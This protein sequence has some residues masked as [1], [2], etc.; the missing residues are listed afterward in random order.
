MDIPGIITAVETN[1]PIIG[2]E[3]LDELSV[4][5]QELALDTFRVRI[6][7]K[8]DGESI[9]GY[10]SKFPITSKEY[11]EFTILK[12]RNI[13]IIN[14]F[15]LFLKEAFIKKSTVKWL[16]QASAAAVSELNMETVIVKTILD[17]RYNWLN[18]VFDCDFVNS[19]EMEHVYR[20]W[21]ENIFKYPGN[22]TTSSKP[23]AYPK[24]YL[25]SDDAPKIITY[26]F[27]IS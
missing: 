6:T 20:S 12:I 21:K 8:K 18:D 15:T 9:C 16:M 1:T 7:L 23:S 3:D 27:N 26:K 19:I 11:F 22:V 2:N 25:L 10:T 13:W 24:Q 4:D 5:V 14:S 17:G